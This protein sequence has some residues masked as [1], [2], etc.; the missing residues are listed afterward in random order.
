MMVTGEEGTGGRRPSGGGLRLFFGADREDKSKV[1]RVAVA[2][3]RGKLKSVFQ[4]GAE[5]GG[6]G[7]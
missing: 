3:G 5:G 6:R 2:G 7:V 1:G 4:T